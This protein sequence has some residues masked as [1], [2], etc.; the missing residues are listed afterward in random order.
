[1]V[2]CLVITLV[3]VAQ[4][5][6]AVADVRL[7]PG[8]PIF[9]SDREPESVRRAVK[10][11]QRDLK[12]VLGSE[13]PVVNRIEAL[14]GKPAIVIAGPESGLAELRH[15]EIV[16][17]EAHGVFV[18]GPHVV[19]QGTDPR[20][21]IY[22]VYTFSGQLL[23]IPPCWF[24][25]TWKP[26]RKDAVTVAAGTEILFPSPAVRWRAWFPNDTDL[27]SP[28]RTRS[29]E[30]S[31]AILETMLRLKLNT[32]EGGMMDASSFDRPFRAGRQVRLARDRGLALTGHHMLIFGSDLNDWDD[33]WTKIRHQDA[34]KR[35]LANVQGLE[36]FW[37][38]HIETGRRE[39]LEMIWLIGFR[40]N[41]DIPFWETFPDA[42]ASSAARA[43]VI[44]GMMARQVALL[45]QVTNDP[46]P[47]MRV[48]L[49]NEN[50]DFFAQGLLR[51]PAEPNLIWTFVA[52]RRDHFPAAD[53]RGYRNDE[54][55]PI[56]YYMNFQFTSS[57]A[58]LAQAEGPWKMEKNFRMVGAISR[59]PLEFSV[60]NAGNIREFLLELSANAAMMLDVDGYDSDRYLEA[61]C[62]KYFGATNAAAVAALYRDFYDA[63]W[64]QKKADLPGFDRQYIF[65][66]QR[67]ARAMEQILSQLTNPRNLDPIDPNARDVDG[68]YFGIVPEDSSARTQIE[69]IERGTETA[70]KR[71]SDVVRRADKLL[72]AIPEQ[73]RA[74]FND[75]LRVQAT[76][77]LHL[78]RA[79]Q[80]V[81]R[82]MT[83]LPDRSQALEFL[84]AARQSTGAMREALR[85]AEHDT[86]TRWYDGDRLFGLNRLGE[87]ID[88]AF[89]DLGKP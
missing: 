36:E 15:P 61:F 12:S 31:D 76:F 72:P 52:A 29:A 44:D 42:P 34:P 57:G 66:D 30:N 70:I 79:L 50:S 41:R 39:Q 74:F 47:V 86:F 23:G 75:N 77:M 24:W 37:R 13:S 67:Y 9:V 25:A 81:A 19:L 8:A 89:A 4:T 49:Y 40:G 58:H 62:G 20:G 16:G 7:I 3:V 83:A 17:R 26:A 87:R 18:R 22:A 14:A 80:S 35:T 1:M 56:G 64:T 38:Y 65:Q 53:V 60:V 21:T 63:Y 2:S 45:K 59:R 71:L 85:E 68:R 32:L 55:R 54:N 6:P 11:L 5:Q 27:L 10:D 82:A 28:W 51:P 48:T 88:R 84:H 33:Y 73:G 43:H 69:A 78:N 46:A